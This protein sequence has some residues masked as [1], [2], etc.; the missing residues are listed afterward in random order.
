[1]DGQRVHRLSGIQAPPR[2]AGRIQ[3]QVHVRP[4]GSARRVM[5][6]AGQ[7]SARY[8]SQLLSAS[9]SVA[10]HRIASGKVKGLAFMTAIPIALELERSSSLDTREMLIREVRRGLLGRP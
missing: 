3:R 9:H 7:P 10:V 5:R 1:M 8:V 6:Y 4:N 2:S